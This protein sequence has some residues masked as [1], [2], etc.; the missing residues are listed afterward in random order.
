MRLT[1]VDLLYFFTD[2]NQCRFDLIVNA[3]DNHEN[4]HLLSGQSWYKAL[5]AWANDS[6][7]PVL[8]IDPPV[9]GGGINAKWSLCLGLPLAL[10]ERCGQPYL[11]DVGLPDLVFQACAITYQS[12]FAHKFVVPLHSIAASP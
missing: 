5:T 8:S 11:C 2:L 6:R 3:L 4:R 7:A 1:F 12:P 9:E 10:S